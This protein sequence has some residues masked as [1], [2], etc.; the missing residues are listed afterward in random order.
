MKFKWIFIILIFYTITYFNFGY[1]D[2]FERNPYLYTSIQADSIIKYNFGY[3]YREENKTI[4]PK[5]IS[6]KKINLL[7][8]ST[9]LHKE[10]FPPL[11]DKNNINFFLIPLWTKKI[12]INSII[13]VDNQEIYIEQIHTP[14]FEFG[15]YSFWHWIIP[16]TW[17]FTR[18]IPLLKID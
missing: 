4:Y 18:K 17:E 8:F 16:T 1:F 3:L 11:T 9:I 5:E 15:I 6:L 12:I 13:E 2:T 10:S 7:G 14:Y